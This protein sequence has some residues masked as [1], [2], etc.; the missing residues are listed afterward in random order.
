[1]SML[2]IQAACPC[3]MTLCFMPMNDA[4]PCCMPTIHVLAACPC[5]ISML[6]GHAAYTCMLMSILLLH[7]LCPCCMSLLHVHYSWSMS[8]LHEKAAFPPYVN[9]TCECCMPMLPVHVACPCCLYMLPV[10]PARPSWLSIQ[11]VHHACPSCMATLNVYGVCPCFMPMLP[12]HTLMFSCV[13][14]RCVKSCCLT[15]LHVKISS[16]NALRNLQRTRFDIIFP[17]ARLTKS[18]SRY[19]IFLTILVK[20]LREF[21]SESESPFSR[22]CYKGIVTSTLVHNWSHNSRP[23]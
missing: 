18:E 23:G 5:C 12:V 11:H 20:I 15:Y 2:Y 16:K 3:S 8:I 10:H 4:Y 6:H 13:S 17:I 22:K 19:K 1:M 9:Y 21:G 7:A 14:I